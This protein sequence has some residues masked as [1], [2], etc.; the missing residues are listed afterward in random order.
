[1]ELQCGYRR[2][3]KYSN[4]IITSNLKYPGVRGGAVR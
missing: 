1:M 4:L 3:N 2:R